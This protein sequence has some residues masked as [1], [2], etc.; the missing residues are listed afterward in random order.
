MIMDK[1][2]R[3]KMLVEDFK[4]MFPGDEKAIRYAKNLPDETLDELEKMGFSPDRKVKIDPCAID[5][6][7]IT[8]S[9]RAEPVKDHVFELRRKR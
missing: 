5:T 7:L 1:D 4:K 2:E 8:K 3:R 6:K 9:E